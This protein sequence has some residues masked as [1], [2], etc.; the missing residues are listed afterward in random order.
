MANKKNSQEKYDRA[1]RNRGEDFSEPRYPVDYKYQPHNMNTPLDEQER[2]ISR[3]ESRNVYRKMSVL[4]Q[5]RDQRDFYRTQDVENE[6]YAGIDPRRRKELADGGLISED[7]N[8]MANLP[9]QAVH[10]EYPQAG[11]Y[12]T[13]YLDD[14]VR[15]MERANRFLFNDAE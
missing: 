9:R 4:E 12:S 15:G 1:T 14:T 11:Y 6:F 7:R 8:A 10:H 13:P 5:R 3:D 2:A